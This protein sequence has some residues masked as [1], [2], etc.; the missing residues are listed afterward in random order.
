M[1]CAPIS[2][3]S[4]S[5]SV[6]NAG[7]LTRFI[8][9]K[10]TLSGTHSNKIKNI[11]LS[12]TLPSNHKILRDARSYLRL[13]SREGRVVGTFYLHELSETFTVNENFPSDA[14]Y[15]GLTLYYCKEGAQGLCL[16]KNIL[17]TVSLDDALPPEDLQINYSVP[18]TA[19]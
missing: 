10:I 5:S 16:M 6:Q 19:Y 9:D 15:I 11:R 2:Q 18:V 3:K 8:G 17:F 12:I 7:D 13:F 14:A 4:T 1:S